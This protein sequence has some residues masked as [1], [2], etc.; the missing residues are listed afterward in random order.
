MKEADGWRDLYF[1]FYALSLR[2]SFDYD[3]QTL[4]VLK[5]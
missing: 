1:A 2:F 5:N 4:T 3:V